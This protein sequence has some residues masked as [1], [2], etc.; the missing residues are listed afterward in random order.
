MR[1]YNL[2]EMGHV[3]NIL[4]PVDI[5]G[6]KSADV[7]SMANYNRAQIIIQVGVSTAAWT[8]IVVNECTALAGTK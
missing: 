2:V 1:G 4:P 6:G 5:T 8:S 3:V 7:F